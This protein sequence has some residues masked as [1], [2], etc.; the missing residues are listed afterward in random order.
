MTVEHL[1]TSPKLPEAFAPPRQTWIK[2]E[3]VDEKAED[4]FIRSMI[5]LAGFVV[6]LVAIYFEFELAT[7]KFIFLVIVIGLIVIWMKA[8]NV[9]LE[10]QLQNI[11]LQRDTWICLR[12]GDEWIGTP[13]DQNNN[14]DPQC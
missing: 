5:Y 7:F 10:R 4:R 9:H 12:C 11:A 6:G 14:R 8:S 3:K 1:L 13:S 2:A